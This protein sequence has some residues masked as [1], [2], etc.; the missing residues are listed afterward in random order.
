MQCYWRLSQPVSPAVG[1]VA[2]RRLAHAAQADKS[3]WDLTQLLRVPGTVN[4]K[5]EEWPIVEVV[6]IS[7]ESYSPAELDGLLPEIEQP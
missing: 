7:E 4:H 2:N 1:E 3:G 6:S 5:Y